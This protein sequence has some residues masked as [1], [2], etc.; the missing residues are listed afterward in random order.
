GTIRLD[1][2]ILF[3]PISQYDVSRDRK[4]IIVDRSRHEILLFN[5]AGSYI[6]TLDAEQDTP[7]APTPHYARFVF[8]G[9]ILM[10]TDGPAFLFDPDGNCLD[11][12]D[13][14]T[15]LAD[16]YCSREDTLFTYVRDRAPR[17]MI[18]GRD[19]DL[20]EELVLPT[21]KS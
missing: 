9:Q 18:Y 3:G 14:L 20:I 10:S 2:S 1:P 4:M 12:V 5:P 6:R 13:E 8:D 7:G 15:P 19:F 17:A 21:P 16:S 11:R